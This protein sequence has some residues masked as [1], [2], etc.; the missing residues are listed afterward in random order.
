[1]K[2]LCYSAFIAFWSCIATLLA[3]HAL[4]TGEPPPATGTYSLVELA[5]HASGDDCWLAINGKVYDLTGYLPRHP[6]PAPILQA[7]CGRE[8]SEAMRTKGY[9]R[10]HSAAAWQLLDSY[11]IGELAGPSP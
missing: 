11:L 7:W 5:A 10:D 6:A 2:K 1:M 9:G 3:V 4:A 8:A